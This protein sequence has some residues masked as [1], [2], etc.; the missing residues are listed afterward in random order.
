MSADSFTSTVDGRVAHF[1]VEYQT[2]RSVDGAGNISVRSLPYGGGAV[3][4]SAGRAPVTRTFHVFLG[5]P[6]DMNDLIHCRGDH[7]VLVCFE[8][9][10]DAT[11]SQVRGGLWYPDGRQ[12]ADITV[13]MDTLD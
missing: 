13:I 5:S 11:L 8:G 9:T 10:F 1:D 4:Q 2:N 7:G 12:E 6:S 3:I